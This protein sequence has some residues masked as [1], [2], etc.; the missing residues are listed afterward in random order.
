LYHGKDRPPTG[1]R[2]HRRGQH[3]PGRK[4]QTHRGLGNRHMTIAH[5]EKA[6]RCEPAK[7]RL[8]AAPCPRQSTPRPRS[9]G[10][11][12][13]TADAP[14]NLAPRPAPSYQVDLRRLQRLLKPQRSK[15]R[16]QPLCQRRP[17]RLRRPDHQ[18]IV[19]TSSRHLERPL[20]HCPRTSLKFRRRESPLIWLL[21]IS[22]RG[23]GV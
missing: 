1:T 11:A 10:A 4:T 23:F 5:P 3:K 14:P 8:A 15:N 6:A 13:G 22:K 16:R 12:T 18:N 17:A 20:R 21:R 2:V 9:Y 7:P 19:P